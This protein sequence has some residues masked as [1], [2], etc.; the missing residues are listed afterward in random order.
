[1]L[2]GERKVVLSETLDQRGCVRVITLPHCAT[3]FAAND[4]KLSI[5]SIGRFIVL[6]E[7]AFKTMNLVDQ[8]QLASTNGCAG[9]R[10][11]SSIGGF[12]VNTTDEPTAMIC[13]LR[14]LA[15]LRNTSFR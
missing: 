8:W 13:P 6:R 10:A 4:E 5:G 15:D 3:S 2:A 9:L 11:A 14:I 7:L 12:C 1:M